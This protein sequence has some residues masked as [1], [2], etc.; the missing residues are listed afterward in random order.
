[1][2]EGNQIVQRAHGYENFAQQ[3]QGFIDRTRKQ[4]SIGTLAKLLYVTESKKKIAPDK[5][6]RFPGNPKD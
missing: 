4:T 6:V 5:F 1:M 2:F 3:T